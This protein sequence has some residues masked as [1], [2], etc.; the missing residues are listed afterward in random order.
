M[1]SFI[2]QQLN[3]F[4]N[5]LFIFIFGCIES[6]LLR[7]GFLSLQPVGT[8][9]QCSSL[10]SHCRGF[11]CYGAQ[12]LGHE[13]SV[14]VKCRTQSTGSVAVTHRLNSSIVCGIFQNQGLSTCP[15]QWQCPFHWQADSLP[16][17]HQECAVLLFLVKTLLR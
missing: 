11:C 14:F 5:Y 2:E 6:L 13:G 12:A 1:L 4:L 15:L 8:A 10:A 9:L 17:K 3:L 7:T 16:L